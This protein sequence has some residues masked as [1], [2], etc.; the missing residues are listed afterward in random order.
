MKASKTKTGAQHRQEKALRRTRQDVPAGSKILSAIEEA[1]EI[2]RSEGLESKRLTIRT[3]KVAPVS[4]SYHPG[5]VKRVRELLGTSQAVLA[6][7]LGV[8]VNTV[9]AW[10]QGKRVPQTIACRF[11]SEIEANPGYWRQ[12]IG[13][14]P[15]ETEPR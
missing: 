3:Y 8:N 2:L 9:R 5:D 1:T 4:P 14:A 7:F 13:Q 11:L 12:R 10:E 6:K 15:L